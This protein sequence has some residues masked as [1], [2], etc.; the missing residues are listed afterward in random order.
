MISVDASKWGSVAMA[1]AHNP[2]PNY[3]ARMSALLD[4][5]ETDWGDPVANRGNLVPWPFPQFNHALYGIDITNG[6]LNVILGEEKNRKTTLLINVVMHYMMKAK[7]KPATA[8]DVLESGMSVKRYRD[9]FVSM[10]ASK[11]L[12]SIGHY[13]KRCS[14]CNSSP[15]KELVITPDFLRYRTR[16]HAQKGAIE[17][18]LAQMQDWPLVLYGAHHEQGDTRNLETSVQSRSSRWRWLIKELGV[19][20]IGLDHVQQYAFQDQA[21]DY[22]KQLR[23]V[24]AT[25]DIV[26]GHSIACLM[27]SQVSLSSLKEHRSGTGSVNAAGGK[28]AQQEANVVL[29]TEYKPDWEYMKIAIL[30]SRRS[31]SFAVYQNVEPNS[32]CFYDESRSTEQ[33]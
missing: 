26:A 25:S 32:G 31:A 8:L 7:N 2:T 18:A 9:T 14:V 11:Y 29:Q 4:Q 30:E 27:L 10:M 16:T 13:P 23:A 21:T 33:E 15:C 17:W 24:A 20:I 6:E 19:Q 3:D 1:S 12:M 22:E 28:K 5:C